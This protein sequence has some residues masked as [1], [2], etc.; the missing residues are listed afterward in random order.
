MLE[1]KNIYKI[2]NQGLGNEITALS[3]INCNFNNNDFV[4]VIGNNGSGKSTFMNIVA[5]NIFAT[6]G[7]IIIHNNNVTTL[8]PYQRASYISRVFQN[9]SHG[10]ADELSI[11]ENFRIASIRTQGKYLKTMNQEF[12]NKVKRELEILN[13]GFENKLDMKVGELSGGQKQALSLLLAV[14]D[15][16][17]IILM[18]EPTAALDPK[19]Q[20]N[21]M[22]LTQQLH[23]K[24]NLL[25]LLVSHNMQDAIEYGNKIVV[26][27]E[28]HLV[29][30]ID[31]EKTQVSVQ[32]LI[33]YFY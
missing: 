12:K 8:Q 15:T 25:T 31:K 21:I 24:Y 11:I 29:E 18:D 30:V 1:L 7:S 14:A 27:K 6:S 19:A 26:L 20:K 9:S 16:T 2:Y 28:G 33:S 23:T 13:M 4:I 22:Q 17:K 5:G 10:V 3:N 32:K